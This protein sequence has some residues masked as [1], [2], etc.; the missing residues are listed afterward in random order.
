VFREQT[1]AQKENIAVIKDQYKKVQE[2]YKRKMGEM[3]ERLVKETKKMEI[4]ERRRKHELEGY[5]ADLQNMRKKIGFYHKY[6]T[7]LRRLVEEDQAPEDI[8]F[9]DEG[10]EGDEEE[11]SRDK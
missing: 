7:K 6:I 5:G 2:I 4:N 10:E 8:Q 3:Q 1:K 9:S 11:H